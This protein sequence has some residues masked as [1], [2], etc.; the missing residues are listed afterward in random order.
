[1]ARKRSHKNPE[2][3]SPFTTETV[4]QR[5]ARERAE[6]REI[7]NRLIADGGGVVDPAEIQ[8]A[9]RRMIAREKARG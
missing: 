4:A 6:E 8:E 5:N 3:G 7:A 1:M 9:Y 2:G